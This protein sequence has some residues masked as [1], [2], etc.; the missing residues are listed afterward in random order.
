MIGI[1]YGY[2]VKHGGVGRYISEAILHSSKRREIELLTIENNL[3]LPK[4]VK[5][6]K[7]NCKRDKQFLSLSENLSFSEK[8]KKDA[9]RFNLLHSHGVYSFSPDIYTAHICLKKYF[10][11]V[12][13]FGGENE[14][15]RNLDAVLSLERDI[16]RNSSIITA[17]S[18][19]VADEISE[20]YGIDQDRILIIRGA[21]RLKDKQDEKR[22]QE[23]CLRIGFVGGNLKAKGLNQLVKVCNILKARGINIS[24]TGAGTNQDIENYFL[25]NARFNFDLKGKIELGLDFYSKLDVYACLSVYEAYSLSTLEAM[26]L[27]I[28]VVSSNLNGVFYDNPHENL[29]RANDIRDKE[30]L[31]QI[32]EQA[33]NNAEYRRRVI[34]AGKR[35]SSQASWE[36]ISKSY[37][38]LYSLI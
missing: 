19:K 17:V 6:T 35:I 22:K 12:K 34:E 18:S 38:K 25:A 5:V 27:G 20:S 28:P 8:V 3:H 16:V 1:V 30:E 2:L 7:L 29:A 9:K 23:S 21:S 10:E 33:F 13:D 32:V 26:S 37:D 36:S 15:P 11:I 4:G 24:V 14:L 31:V